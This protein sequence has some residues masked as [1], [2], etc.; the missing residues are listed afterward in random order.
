MTQYSARRQRRLRRSLTWLLLGGSLL[1]VVTADKFVCR[2]LVVR[3]ALNGVFDAVT[4]L[5]I[6]RV[7]S[8]LGVVETSP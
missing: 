4:P 6:D 5:I 1:Q 8:E 7:Q 3:S 2:D